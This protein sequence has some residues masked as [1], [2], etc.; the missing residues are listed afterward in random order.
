MD[1]RCLRYLSMNALSCGEVP[2]G[3]A[4]KS[5]IHVRPNYNL[6]RLAWI[7]VILGLCWGYV[8]AMFGFCHLN[9]WP[10]LIEKT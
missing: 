8:E 9:K 10:S 3:G 2:I 4:E 6:I 1:N 7:E 5:H